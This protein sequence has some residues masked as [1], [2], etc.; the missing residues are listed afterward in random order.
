MLR[1][2]SVIN[3]YRN[4]VEDYIKFY[5]LIPGSL[6]IHKCSTHK[7]GIYRA[8]SLNVAVARGTATNLKAIF[9]SNWPRLYAI[10]KSQPLFE[11]SVKI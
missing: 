6:Q 10:F 3:T 5:Y 9:K 4:R 7:P 1:I 11:F 8:G 2:K